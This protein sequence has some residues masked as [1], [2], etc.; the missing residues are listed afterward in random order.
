MAVFRSTQLLPVVFCLLAGEGYCGVIRYDLP[1]LLGEHHYDGSDVLPF[2]RVSQVNTPFGFYSVAQARLVVEGTISA[3]KAHGDGVLREPFDIDLEPSVGATP[4]FARILT[5]ATES[6]TGT[7]RIDDI[8][9]NPFHPEVTPLPNPDGYPPISFQVLFS[10]GPSFSTDYPPLIT[11]VE[12]GELIFASDGVVIDTPIIANVTEAYIVLE[13][14]GVV[15][16]PAS[17]GIAVIA[18]LGT[19]LTTLRLTRRCS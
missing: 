6:S 4:S 5:I 2:G 19:I 12:P 9:V 18:A 17:A 10:V 7:F 1:E 11:P 13:G 14:P 16:E 8:Y 3:G 15:P